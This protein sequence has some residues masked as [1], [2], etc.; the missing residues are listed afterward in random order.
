MIPLL[1]EFNP[2]EHSGIRIE[3]DLAT[4]PPQPNKPNFTRYPLHSRESSCGVTTWA[5][6]TC[7]GARGEIRAL[8]A[9]LTSAAQG[10]RTEQASLGA[11]AS[12]LGGADRA[13]AEARPTERVAAKAF[14]F[15]A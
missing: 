11:K 5:R 6:R 8:V 1:S 14:D 4:R 3:P 10:A 9:A 15:E 2:N 12:L 13:K 7:C